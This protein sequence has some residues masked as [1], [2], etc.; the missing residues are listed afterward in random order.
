MN[1][2]EMNNIEKTIY[3]NLYQWVHYEIDDLNREQIIDKLKQCSYSRNT[4]KL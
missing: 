3:D 4:D 2:I 1:N